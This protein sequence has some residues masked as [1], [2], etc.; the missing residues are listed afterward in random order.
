MTKQHFIAL[1]AEI[2]KLTPESR[3]DAATAVAVVAQKF[4]P[5]FDVVRFFKACGVP[6]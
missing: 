1:A 6:A 2:A 3:G 4:N 5:N